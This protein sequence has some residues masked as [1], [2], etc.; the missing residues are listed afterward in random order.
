MVHLT[1]IYAQALGLA[2]K[3]NGKYDDIYYDTAVIVGFHDAED[4]LVESM[5][6]ISI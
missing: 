2:S 5:M 4:G 3:E 6:L 1:S